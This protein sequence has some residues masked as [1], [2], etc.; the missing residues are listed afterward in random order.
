[1]S[2]AWRSWDTAGS[3]TI[4][5]WLIG[6]WVASRSGLRKR[7]NPRHHQS[8]WLQSHSPPYLRCYY[9][10][11]T[12]LLHYVNNSIKIQI[13][14][15]KLEL[16]EIFSFVQS[17]VI[18]SYIQIFIQIFLDFISWSI[19]ILFYYLSFC[20]HSQPFSTRPLLEPGCWINDIG[21]DV[22]KLGN[23]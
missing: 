17:L 2:V 22:T 3:P 7:L 10:S 4:I 16:F 12:R 1:M 13:Q 11:I 21:A 9:Y 14:S 8:R 18:L 5:C 23:K 19:S 6:Y 20:S 15:Q